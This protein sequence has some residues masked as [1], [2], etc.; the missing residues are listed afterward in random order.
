MKATLFC[1]IFLM[2]EL[3]KLVVFSDSHGGG[4]YIKKAL[5]MH[6]DADAAIFL[7]D[8][9]WDFL[10]LKAQFP[11]TAF[12]AVRGNCDI[13]SSLCSDVPLTEEL[14]LDGYKL[15]FCHGHTYGVKYGYESI[16]GAARARGADAVL[17]GHTH[18]RT[19]RYLPEDEDGG[20]LYLI[21]PGSIGGRGEGC[22]KSYCIVRLEKSGILV[23]HAQVR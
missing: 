20:A 10:P 12:F 8:G 15:F 1:N 9:L 16:I 6:R 2:E 19:E 22:I 14:T 5:Q 23:C 21:N 13:G 18:I 7:G 11:N 3:M 17:F 4:I